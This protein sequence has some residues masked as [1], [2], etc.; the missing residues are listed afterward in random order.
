MIEVLRDHLEPLILFPDQVLHRDTD[1]LENHERS[2]ARPPALRLE[3]TDADPWHVPLDQDQTHTTASR[4]S[5]PDGRREEVSLRPAAPPRCEEEE[6][7]MMTARRTVNGTSKWSSGGVCEGGRA[8]DDR[9]K[10]KMTW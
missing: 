10:K 9:I 4:A 2:P 6:M 1:I 7:T 8:R 3:T 5:C